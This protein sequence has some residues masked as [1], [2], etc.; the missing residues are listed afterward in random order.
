MMMDD[1]EYGVI[2]GMLGRR[3]RS[4]RRKPQTNNRPTQIFLNVFFTNDR[5]INTKSLGDSITTQ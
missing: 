4:T 2:D 3:N 1:D 5:K